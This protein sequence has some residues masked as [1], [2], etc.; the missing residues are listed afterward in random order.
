[1]NP[2]FSIITITYNA[3]K[4][5]RP[6]MLSVREQSFGDFEHIIVDG[7]SS[8]NTV[9]VARSL[10]SDNIRILCEKDAGLYDAMNKGLRMAKG[11][12][13]I[14]LNAGDSFA[15]S[16]TLESFAVAAESNPDIIYGDTVIVDEN[17]NVKGPRHLSVPES[18]TFDSFSRGMLVCHQAFCVRRDIAPLYDLTYRF[19]ADYDWTVKC[20]SV[21]EPS[22]CVNLHT[23]VI[24]YLDDGMTEK[25]KVASLKE[26]YRIMCKHY[27]TM[28]AL[29][30]HISFLP[31]VVIRTAMSKCTAGCSK[32][33]NK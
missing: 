4:E 8:D 27:G 20:I 3:H 23:V 13:L 7:L 32:G 24:H 30:R 12:Y 16:S 19:S 25:H 18:L 1:M 17:R 10:A 2:L 15:S 14:F 5:L 26:R 11:R 22:K 6:T 29:L 21:T 9:D 28:K 33:I 31:R